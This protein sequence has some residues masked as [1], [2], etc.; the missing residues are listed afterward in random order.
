MTFLVIHSPDSYMYVIK[1]TGFF[2]NIYTSMVAAQ[3][4]LEVVQHILC[5]LPDDP[6]VIRPLA[7]VS[8]TWTFAAQNTL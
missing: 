3:L 1:H 6:R 4:P 8:R 5:F 7:L 2:L